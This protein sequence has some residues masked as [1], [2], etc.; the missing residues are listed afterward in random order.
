MRLTDKARNEILRKIINDR[1]LDA[2]MRH[3]KAFAKCVEKEVRTKYAK[4]LAFYR[5]AM[6]HGMEGALM[7]RNY[8]YIR[9]KE[10]ER[11][12]QCGGLVI[13]KELQ[14]VFDR[15]DG[16]ACFPDG[17]C[18]RLSFSVPSD[19]YL[20]VC[21]EFDI[22]RWQ[23]TIDEAKEA[24]DTLQQV[25]WSA[26]SVKKLKE[27]VPGIERYL[28]NDAECTALVPIETVRRARAI[29]GAEKKKLEADDATA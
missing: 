4:E 12:L 7:L 18:Q 27:L 5:Y 22:A 15:V 28:P 24:H 6:K 23:K 8:T 13:D 20:T 3:K 17:S 19:N 29:V 25:L 1:F 16:E 9:G 26:T 21:T 14:E 10:S 11:D 2:M